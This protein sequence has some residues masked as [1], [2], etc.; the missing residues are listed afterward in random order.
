MGDYKPQFAFVYPDMAD[1][2][3]KIKFD[4]LVRESYVPVVH[5]AFLRDRV[6]EKGRNLG[7]PPAIRPIIDEEASKRTGLPMTSNDLCKSRLSISYIIDALVNG[8]YVEFCH[9]E[10]MPIVKQW[11]QLYLDEYKGVDLTKFPD[12][13]AFLKNAQEA[14]NILNGNLKRMDDWDAEKHP[15]KLKITDLISLI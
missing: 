8:H 14:L 2:L 15:Q 4:V 6:D 13:V 12:R 5:Y 1:N 3:T 7:P 9:L 11:I 10:D